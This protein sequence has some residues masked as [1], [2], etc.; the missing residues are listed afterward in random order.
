MEIQTGRVEI[1]D[2][3]QDRTQNEGTRAPHSLDFVGVLDLPGGNCSTPLGT[4]SGTAPVFNLPLS[5]ENIPIASNLIGL[6]PIQNLPLTIKTT[7]YCLSPISPLTI[8]TGPLL[9]PNPIPANFYIL[10]LSLLIAQK[11]YLQGPVTSYTS[12]AHLN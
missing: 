3:Q 5:S 6:N 9:S 12:Q 10:L 2:S 1:P 8:K 7:P 11:P 4:Q